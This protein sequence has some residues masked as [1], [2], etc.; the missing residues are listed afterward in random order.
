[1]KKR[2]AVLFLYG[3]L[4]ASLLLTFRLAD[5]VAESGR[6]SG[7]GET[8]ALSSVI[9]GI[10]YRFPVWV[11]VVV[12]LLL[13]VAIRL[14]LNRYYY[15][16]YAKS[17]Q[18]HLSRPAY[19]HINRYRA[20]DPSFSNDRFADFVGKL[21]E[22]LCACAASGDY[23]GVEEQVAPE[24]YGA[25]AGLRTDLKMELLQLKLDGFL[26]TEGWDRIA[27]L[28]ILKKQR[29]LGRFEQEWI[30]ERESGSDGE[31]RLCEVNKTNGEGRG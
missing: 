7:V 20:V 29:S 17:R 16:L 30:F 2:I 5:R 6:G 19:T 13:V 23:A 28:M 14:G 31:W 24:L 3:L 18:Y 21:Q 12:F 9:S 22:T 15:R 8:S 10:A 26:R 25:L 11:Y 1:M 27:V 4:L